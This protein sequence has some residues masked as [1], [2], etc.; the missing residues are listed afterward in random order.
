M[1][2]LTVLLLIGVILA[3]TFLIGIGSSASATTEDDSQLS[4]GNGG[5]DHRERFTGE[6]IPS[7]GPAVDRFGRQ[8]DRG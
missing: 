8:L 3:A 5:E 4:A 1:R 6:V 2:R 7:I